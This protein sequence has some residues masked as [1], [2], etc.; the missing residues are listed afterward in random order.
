MAAT[1]VAS[2]LVHVVASW[3]LVVYFR[4]GVLGAAMALNISWGAWRCRSCM[5]SAAGAP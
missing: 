3:L 2:F 4:F 1:A 5:P